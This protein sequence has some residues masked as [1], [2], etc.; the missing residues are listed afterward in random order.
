MYIIIFK[1]MDTF[2]TTHVISGAYV[3]GSNGITG[4]SF[5]GV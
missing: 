1:Y 5:R 2:I 3:L 4:L